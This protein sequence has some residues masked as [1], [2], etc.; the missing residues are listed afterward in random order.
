[1]PT[2]P[3]TTW[4]QG[5]VWPLKHHGDARQEHVNLKASTTFAAGTVLGEITASPGTYGPYASGNTDGTQNPTLILQYPC[6]VD[7]S[8]N[9]ALGDTASGEHGVTVKSAPAWRSGVFKTTELVGLDA[10]AVS[11]LGRLIRGSVADGELVVYGE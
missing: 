3:T 2:S 4:G 1:M 5:G 9:I 7:A 6:V 11:K 10:N 8:G